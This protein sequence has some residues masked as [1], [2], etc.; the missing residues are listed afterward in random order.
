MKSHHGNLFFSEF[1]SYEKSDESDNGGGGGG[2]EEGPGGLAG[3]GRGRW[4]FKK[5][6]MVVEN[7]NTVFPLYNDANGTY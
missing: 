1:N 4:W 3:G 7:V 2:E 5:D 6:A